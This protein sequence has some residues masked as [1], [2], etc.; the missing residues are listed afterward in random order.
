MEDALGNELAVGDLVAYAVRNNHQIR[1]RWGAVVRIWPEMAEMIGDGTRSRYTVFRTSEEL[2]K[3]L[4]GFPLPQTND[5]CAYAIKHGGQRP[6]LRL[7]HV[8]AVMAD[9]HTLH[10]KGIGICGRDLRRS[11][12]NCIVC[13][14]DEDPMILAADQAMAGALT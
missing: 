11:S 2:V 14:K 5:L 3:V 9:G 10:L 1:L 13:Q 8:V 4:R 6:K 7:G 12:A